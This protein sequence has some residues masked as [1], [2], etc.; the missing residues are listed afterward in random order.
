MSQ[1]NDGQTIKI[2]S[3]LLTDELAKSLNVTMSQHAADAI[4]HHKLNQ[5]PDNSQDSNEIVKVLEVIIFTFHLPLLF[6]FQ[7]QNKKN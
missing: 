2:S 7:L 1:L 3:D 6:F 5:D 4:D